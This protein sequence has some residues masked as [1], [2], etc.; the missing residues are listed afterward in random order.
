M[1][2][3]LPLEFDAVMKRNEFLLEVLPL[4]TR[5]QSFS[6]F[7][8]P[9]EDDEEVDLVLPGIIRAFQNVKLDALEKLA[10]RLEGWFGGLRDGSTANSIF[11][12]WHTPKIRQCTVVDFIPSTPVSKHITSLNVEF[13]EDISDVVEAEDLFRFIGRHANLTELS[14]SFSPTNHVMFK[15]RKN[16]VSPGGLKLPFLRKLKIR[17]PISRTYDLIKVLFYSLSRTAFK[18]EEVT[19]DFRICLQEIE[20]RDDDMFL[21]DNFHLEL[22]SCLRQLSRQESLKSFT[23]N[24]GQEDRANPFHSNNVLGSVFSNL[25]QIQHLAISAPDF[26]APTIKAFQAPLRTLSLNKCSRFDNQFIQDLFGVLKT[27]GALDSFEKLTVDGCDNLHKE[28][29]MNLLP[30]DK[31]EWEESN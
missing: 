14:L 20:D 21:S 22:D 8:C 25:P 16:A 31:V 5:W 7:F 6:L 2:K 27:R 17:T 26:P 10:V 24:I 11:S 28:V 30:S 3:V 19:L 15:A 13:V 9:D 18:L 4:S 29:T 23:L 1:F 12:S